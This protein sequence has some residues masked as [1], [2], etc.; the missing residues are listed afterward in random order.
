MRT[1]PSSRI[2][3]CSC[4]VTYFHICHNV[5]IYTL[6]VVYVYEN[7]MKNLI[8]HCQN[9]SNIQRKYHI[10]RQNGYLPTYMLN[11]A[12]LLVDVFLYS[13]EATSYRSSSRKT[14]RNYP[15][16]RRLVNKVC[17]IPISD[18]DDWLKHNFTTKEMISIFQLWT[19][20]WY[21]ATFQ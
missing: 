1:W 8:P 13:Y 17:F 20:N 12:H 21:V 2:L 9:S 10:K 7:K 11:C 18:S 16:L 15:E 19:S 14:K 5:H 6:V 4:I 3:K